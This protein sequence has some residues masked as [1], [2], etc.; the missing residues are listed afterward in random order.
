MDTTTYQVTIK[1]DYASA[2]LED[3]RLDEAIEFMPDDIPQWQIDESLRRLKKMK[4]NPSSTMDSETFF[5]SVD[6]DAE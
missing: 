1:K 4:E 5:N 6:D 2:I 3:L